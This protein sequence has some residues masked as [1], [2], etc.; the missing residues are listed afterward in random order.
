MHGT[1]DVGVVHGQVP[2]DQSERFAERLREA[3]GRVVLLL[4]EGAPHGF[5]GNP[6]S[7][8]TIRM[9]EAAVP[10]FDEHLRGAG[11]R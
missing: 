10:F 3:G 7:E 9:W 1:A 2:V 6:A 5:T 4:L 8:H 11:T